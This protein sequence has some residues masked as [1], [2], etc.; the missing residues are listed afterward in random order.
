MKGGSY[1]HTFDFY[2]IVSD[3]SESIKG[4]GKSLILKEYG[5]FFKRCLQE[6]NGLNQT[7]INSCSDQG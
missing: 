6:K 5:I 4:I 1:L 3:I 2:E 7:I